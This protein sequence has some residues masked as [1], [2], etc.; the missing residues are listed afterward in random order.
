MVEATLLPPG[1]E[2]GARVQGI[3]RNLGDL[4]TSRRQLR[5]GL[6]VNQRQASGPLWLRH[7]AEIRDRAA[8]GRVPDAKGKPEAPRRVRRSRSIP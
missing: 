4:L 5:A 3:P 7:P 8:N 2:T 6:P 1:S